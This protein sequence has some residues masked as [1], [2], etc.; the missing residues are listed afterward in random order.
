MIASHLGPTRCNPC[1]SVPG[2]RGFWRL[3]LVWSLIIGP[4]SLLQPGCKSSPPAPETPTQDAAS[5]NALID[6]CLLC[7]STREMQRG[8]IIDGLPAWYL[9]LQ[10]RRFMTGERGQNPDNRSEHL[11]GSGISLLQTDDDLAT[12]VRHFSQLPPANHVKTIRGNNELG[13][14]HYTFCATCHGPNGRGREE[15]QAPP[16]IVQEDWYLFDQLNRI[17]AGL[18]GGQ[19]TNSTVWLMHQAVQGLNTQDFRDVVSYIN[20]ELAGRSPTRTD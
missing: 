12:V 14:Q 19:D 15:I 3:A 8:P 10:L 13:A 9:E 18:R 4:W 17:K 16:L 1:A 7:H 20:D 11:M 6:S 5:V 2:P